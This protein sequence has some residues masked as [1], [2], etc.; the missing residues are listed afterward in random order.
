[1]PVDDARCC[2]IH[3]GKRKVRLSNGSYFATLLLYYL[4]ALLIECRIVVS[5]RNG[6]SQGSLKVGEEEGK[7][8]PMSDDTIRIIPPLSSIG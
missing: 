3:A 4:T 1:M 7:V 5:V 2:Q 6:Q 8:G